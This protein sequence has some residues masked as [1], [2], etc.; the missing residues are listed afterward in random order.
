MTQWAH[1]GTPDGGWVDSPAGMQ[2]IP[3]PPKL[4]T[5]AKL[6]AAFDVIFDPTS[7]G[8]FLGDFH[9]LPELDAMGGYAVDP[10]RLPAGTRITTTFGHSEILAS[11]DFETYSEAGYVLEPSGRVRGVG[12]QGKG[13]LPV[14]GVPI[15]ATHPSC[16]VLS[17]VYDLKDGRG[18]RHWAP[19][20]PAPL[21]LFDHIAR[22]GLLE[23]WNISFEFWIWNVVCVRKYGWPVLPLPQ[24][25]CAMAKSRRYSLPGGLGMAAKV[26]GTPRKE[27]D[28][29]RLLEKLSRPLTTTKNR[30]AVRWTPATAWDDFVK[31][32]KYNDKDVVAEDHASARIPDLSGHELAVWQL[33]QA[34]NLRGVGVDIET[35]DAALDILSQ[36]ERR[37]TRELQEITE[38]HVGS[39]SEVDKFS[40]W[41]LAKGVG[42]VDLTK[43][44]VAETL[45]R[46]DLPPLCR[47]ALEIREILGAANVKKLRTLKLQTSSDGRLREQY[48]YCGADQTG[49]W[50]AGGVQL[51]N[52]TAKGP[53]TCRCESCGKLYGRS[54]AALGCPRCN[55]W[56]FHEENDWTIEGVEQAIED[57]RTRSLDWVEQVWGD[58]VE[59][60]CGCLRGL[61]M[62]R[63]GHEFVCV[64]FSAIEAVV[65][66]C[67]ARCMWRVEVFAT[68]GKIYEASA[69]KATGIS[70]EEI[71]AYKK[72]H[73]THHPARKGVGK[74][75]E[76][77][78]SYGGWVG[79]WKNFGAE[80][81]FPD[82]EAIKQDVLKWREESPEIVDMWGGQFRW[83]GPGKW[84]Y[85]PAL[86]GL[87]GAFIAAVQNP[88]QWFEH[89]DI[90][91]TYRD[92]I[93]FCRLPS[94]RFLHYHRPRLTPAVDKLNRGPC[95]AITFEGYNS[96][97]QKGPVGWIV[98][99]TYGGR[100]FE[101]VVQAV[102]RDIQADALLR[103]EANAYPIV[104]HTHDEGCAEV[105]VGIG[106]VDE[107]VAIMSQR[108]AWASWWPIKAAGWRHKRYQKD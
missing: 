83:V 98:K 11:L 16:E 84:D 63:E 21:D 18:R 43:D 38:G 71:L 48:M 40:Q 8:F 102:S 53:A 51:Q 81:F 91:Y 17:L 14:V 28:G 75:R 35:L 69:A 1:Y 67:L 24:C 86:F 2:H 3:D 103:A 65:A 78:G 74:I 29:K 66:A 42:M 41:L 31:L 68:H 27:P 32:Y 108:P 23:A 92:D 4:N 49:R 76:L 45:K 58:P 26:I 105:P 80:A 20:F 107:L 90:A 37:Y 55:A 61:F 46:N 33:D 7:D 19:G 100:L 50:S 93:V 22:G 104:M 88:G 54:T 52:I 9:A 79:A 77:A 47:R 70:F 59:V 94:G 34:I 96:N 64:D 87:E 12:S 95:V 39:V 5:G 99:E 82:D 30:S 62:A 25:R 15:Y 89:Y 6:P 10:T 36:A 85:T 60:L 13:G 106:S 57:I 97:S 56:L 101:N 44:T 72:Q 73:G